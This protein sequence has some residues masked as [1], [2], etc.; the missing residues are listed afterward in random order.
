MVDAYN[1]NQDGK[2]KEK[3]KKKNEQV[4]KIGQKN[5]NTKIHLEHRE[6]SG[7]P[8]SEFRYIAKPGWALPNTSKPDPDNEKK[9]ILIVYDLLFH[10]K[11]ACD[12]TLVFD[13]AHV[14]NR[15]CSSTLGF[16]KTLFVKTNTRVPAVKDKSIPYWVICCEFEQN[17][18]AQS[19]AMHKKIDFEKHTVP[20]SKEVN[21]FLGDYKAPPHTYIDQVVIAQTLAGTQ[22]PTLNPL[23][24]ALPPPP[25]PNQ[26][27][28]IKPHPSA[29]DLTH[30]LTLNPSSSQ[31]LMLN[32]N[33][34]MWV[35]QGGQM[36]QGTPQLQVGFGAEGVGYAGQW[37][38]D[39]H[40]RGSS[41][42]HRANTL[43]L[44]ARVLAHRGVCSVHKDICMDQVLSKGARVELQDPI[45]P[46]ILI[47]PMIQHDSSYG[48]AQN[49]MPPLPPLQPQEGS[50]NGSGGIEGQRAHAW[51]IESHI[52]AKQTKKIRAKKLWGK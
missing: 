44:K 31:Y 22:I 36:Q 5:A 12:L 8:S 29:P 26:L 39:L 19:E 50:I 23:A 46:Y 9:K 28:P 11:T 34:G 51:T 21:V 49:S 17:Y 1:A 7:L 4:Q 33:Q 32:P 45:N 3:G 13:Y 37:A 6:V 14:S 20:Y 47:D 41:W 43:D 42:D 18:P 40:H 25:A 52:Q 35:Q 24:L 27:A 30:P 2:G 16:S 48:Q 10:G 38:M 15:A